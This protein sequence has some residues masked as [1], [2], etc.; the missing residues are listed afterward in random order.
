MTKKYDMDKLNKLRD[1][2]QRG[3]IMVDRDDPRT[4]AG[5]DEEEIRYIRNEPTLTQLK[6]DHLAEEAAI[7]DN[8]QHTKYH[9]PHYPRN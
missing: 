3:E 1:E 2:F 6:E 4:T 8:T 9:N 5:L 7:E